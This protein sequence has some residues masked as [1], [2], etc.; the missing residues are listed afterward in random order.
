M[1]HLSSGDEQTGSGAQSWTSCSTASLWCSRAGQGT[2]CFGFL[3][4]WETLE[5]PLLSELT[6]WMIL[7]RFSFRNIPSRFCWV[8]SVL[9]ASNPLALL[10]HIWPIFPWP[11][12][13]P[14]PLW[15]QNTL[16]GEDPHLGLREGEGTP[17]FGL[18]FHTRTPDGELIA[19]WIVLKIIARGLQRRSRIYIW[20]GVVR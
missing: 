3:S 12:S 1:K 8:T 17:S 19:K 10:L 7:Q 6:C 16:H 15:W 4:Q 9:L 13:P 5:A 11:L 14:S 2:F 20:A 18:D